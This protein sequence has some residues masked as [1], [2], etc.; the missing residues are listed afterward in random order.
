MNGMKEFLRRKSTL[1]FLLYTGVWSVLAAFIWWGAW[2]LDRSMVQP[3]HAMVFPPDQMMR[4][5]KGVLAGG[6]FIPSDLHWFLG[7]PYWWAELE[8]AVPCWLA[9]LAVRFYLR[10]RGMSSVAGYGAGLLFALSGYSLTLFSAGHMGWFEF[11]SYGIFAFGLVDRAVRKGRWRNWAML[12]AVLAWSAARQADLWMLF[13]GL[14]AFYGAWCL[15]RSAR[16]GRPV[17]GGA[18]VRG[19]LSR[20]AAGLGVCAVVTTLIGMPMFRQAIGG[21][22]ADRDEQIESVAQG[23][24]VDQGDAKAKAVARWEFAT[25]WSMPPEDML[26]FV[27]AGVRGDSSDP[28]V[29]PTRRYWGRLGRPPEDKFEAGRVLPN[30][31]QHTLYL[32]VVTV[33]LALLG[34]CGWFVGGRPKDSDVPF[35]LAAGIV[36]VVLSMGRFT[37][38][39]RAFYALPLMDYLRAPVKFHHLT[40]L[41]VAMLA[42]SGLAVLAGGEDQDRA[43]RFGAWAVGVLALV[44]AICVAWAVTAQ[45]ANVAEIVKTMSCVGVDARAAS[46][47]AH[48]AVRACGAAQ[49]LVLLALAATIFAGRLRG[50]FAARGRLLCA[51]ALV[52]VGAVDLAVN[53]ARYCAPQDLSFARAANDAAA[54]MLSRGPGAYVDFT[55]G[56]LQNSLVAHGACDGSMDLADRSVRY[57]LLPEVAL[58]DAKFAEFLR[59]RRAEKIGGYRISRTGLRRVGSEPAQIFVYEFKDF[60]EKGDKTRQTDVLSLISVLSTLV[61]LGWLVKSAKSKALTRGPLK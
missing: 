48:G 44:M 3:D 52:G 25:G 49:G 23:Q 19:G 5:L 21:N 34:V 26:E 10:G 36:C 51:L 20:L 2:P 61:L 46:E 15:V 57:V 53:D 38:V 12:G 60:V 16:C 18:S 32:G 28:R 50:A 30:Y 40:E 54:D 58:K 41:C 45:S 29:S 1:A 27:A 14:E 42:G 17:C 43:R 39:Y 9:G 11:I 13:T 31:R 24:G 47:L 7:S 59:S 33:A 6:T 56:Q 37:P 55:R 22:L 4:F 8:Y 35:W